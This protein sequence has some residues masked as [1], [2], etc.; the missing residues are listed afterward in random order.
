ELGPLKNVTARYYKDNVF[1]R[2]I[3]QHPDYD[4][5]WQARGVAQHLKSVRYAVMTVGGW[6]DAED[7]YGPLTVYKELERNNPGIYN[8]LV[9]GPFRHGGWAAQGVAH[10]LHGDIY[11]G[12]SLEVFYQREIETPFFRHWLKGPA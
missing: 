9:M 1:W 6:F 11:F 7:L 5:F 8:T 2:E 10:T 3:I 4:A 12:D